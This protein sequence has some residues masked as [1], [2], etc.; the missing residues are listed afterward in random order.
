M[1]LTDSRPDTE[2]SASHAEVPTATT[3]TV[4][5]WLGA[6]DHKPIG[7]RFII[8]GAIMLLVGL[9]LGLVA[10]FE[11]ADA[12]GFQIAS[13]ADEYTQIW[14][15]GRDLVMFGGVVPI[16]IGIGLYLVPL[17]IGASSAAFAR[18]GAAAFWTWALGVDL[19]I[20]SYLLNGGPGGGRADFVM[21]WATGLGMMLFGLVWAMV[22]VLS[23]ILGART[24]GMTTDRV[25]FT[26]W[27]FFVFSLVGILSLPI[28]MAELLLGYLN[29]RYGHLPVTESEVLA[30]VMDGVSFAPSIYWLGI[31]ILGIGVDV[32]GAHT[33]VPVKARKPIMAALTAFGV[34]TFGADMVAMGSVRTVNFNNGLL[35]VGLLGAALPVLAILGLSGLSIRN[36]DFKPR[37]ALLGALLSGVLVLAAAAVSLLSVVEPIMVGL[38]NVIPDAIDL[39][40]TLVVNGTTLHEAVRALMIGAALVA[41]ISALH[42]WAN[43]IWGRRLTESLGSLSLLLAAG[44][45]LLWA[46]GE[47]VAG[48]ADRPFYSSLGQ[49]EVDTSGL[50]GTMGLISAVGVLALLGSAALLVLN[51]ASNVFGSKSSGSSPTEWTGSTLEWAT[52]SPPGIGNFPGPPIVTSANPLLDGEL[53]FDG[54][55]NDITGA[56]DESDAEGEDA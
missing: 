36:G 13:D 46:L 38:E 49:A 12:G 21:L 26:T 8:L 39:N 32:I 11:S 52:A 1:A 3:D 47:L 5:G 44:G 23:T 48:I 29:V 31:P 40:N 50:V 33:G 30:A 17:Q 27:G 24:V 7:R 37:T 45:S 28:T 56:S 53:R 18:G 10:A 16:L 15:V 51:L 19:L 35:V 34:L 9:A 2:R 20:I 54:F 42:H 22:I 4:D 55:T 25:P 14:S 6:T 43:K 41:I